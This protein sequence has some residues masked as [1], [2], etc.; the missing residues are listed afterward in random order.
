MTRAVS[1]SFNWSSRRIL[2][3]NT[4]KH[5][6]END[7]RTDRFTSNRV[8]PARSQTRRLV[9]GL[10][11]SGVGRSPGRRKG[12]K[13]KRTIGPRP[14]WSGT[15]I[16]VLPSRQPFTRHRDEPFNSVV[17]HGAGRPANTQAHLLLA[18]VR[19][20][21]ADPQMAHSFKPIYLCQTEQLGPATIATVHVRWATGNPSA[22][23]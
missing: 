18:P 6:S 19:N 7:S 12:R 21:F 23:T 17:V 13:C 2:L 14:G 3:G 1:I 9:V 15:S 10:S 20:F 11:L 8:A 4:S 16:E 5:S 22:P